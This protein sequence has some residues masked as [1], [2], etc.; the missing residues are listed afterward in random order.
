MDDGF[1]CDGAEPEKS[2][3]ANGPMTISLSTERS[4]SRDLIST[5]ASEASTEPDTR[6]VPRLALIDRRDCSRK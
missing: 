6:S 5:S 3:T 2:R 1:A 4:G